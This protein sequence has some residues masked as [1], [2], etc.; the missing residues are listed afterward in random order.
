M[1]KYIT[2]FILDGI[3]SNID[4]VPQS[5]NIMELFNNKLSKGT[6]IKR[7]KYTFTTKGKQ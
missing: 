6:N 5:K 1:E 4:F 3:Y 7:S 2:V